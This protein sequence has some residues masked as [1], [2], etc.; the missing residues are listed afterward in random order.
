M[1]ISSF[2]CFFLFVFQW[3]SSVSC[4]LCWGGA[5]LGD[6]SLPEGGSV[7]DESGVVSHEEKVSVTLFFSHPIFWDLFFFF[8][9]YWN[10]Y[11][12]MVM[13]FWLFYFV[14][15]VFLIGFCSDWTKV[16]EDCRK[17][18][19]LDSSSVKV[20]LFLLC[21]DNLSW[22]SPLVIENLFIEFIL[23]L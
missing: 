11:V 7:L 13:G 16:E 14:L 12:L 18:L 5:V 9:F 2:Y 20:L 15:S 19:E 1:L 23:A 22:I 17:A 21:G 10:F 6:Y 8:P 4:F 3:G